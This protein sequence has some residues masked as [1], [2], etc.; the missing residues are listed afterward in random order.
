[1]VLLNLTFNYIWHFMTFYNFHFMRFYISWHLTFH[2]NWHFMKSKIRHSSPRTFIT[3]DIH[4]LRCSSP[5]TIWHIITIVI[6]CHLTYYDIWHFMT[7]DIWTIWYIKLKYNKA[8]YQR[9][10]RQTVTMLNIPKTATNQRYRGQA[11]TLL[12]IP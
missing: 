5:L 12:N 11:V 10:G 9:Y 6:L 7:F 1:M 3:S 4:H 2:D 8:T